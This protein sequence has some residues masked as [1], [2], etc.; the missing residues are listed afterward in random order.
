MMHTFAVQAASVYT[1]SL[2]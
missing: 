2:E 1:C